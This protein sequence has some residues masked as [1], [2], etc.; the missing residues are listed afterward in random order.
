MRD[1]SKSTELHTAAAARGVDVTTV[2]L[3]V[4]DDA[5]V[6]AAFAEVG[7]L[8]V[9]VNNAGV[10]PLGPIE[11]MPLT[12]WK[13]L[14]E[15]N[16]FGAIRCTQAVLPAMRERGSG[17]ILNI[18][19]AISAFTLP[20]FGAYAASKAALEAASEALASE[21][22]PYGI[23]VSIVM[24][25]AVKTPMQ[26]KAIPPPTTVYRQALRNGGL[27]AA[28]LHSGASDAD[29][30]AEV[31]AGLV[32][33]GAKARLRTPAGHGAADLCALAAELGDDELQTLFALPTSEFLDRWQARTG[34]DLTQRPA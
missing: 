5:S 7:S 8:D 28:H 15:T 18:S 13:A 3:D 9:L 24:V 29:V 10:C 26:G 34:Q 16:V 27:F 1:T 25:G 32:T 14:F 22:A 23:N 21:V 31:V 12:E 19:S 30:I 6:S 11:E 4:D 17:H 20:I 2:T 33:G